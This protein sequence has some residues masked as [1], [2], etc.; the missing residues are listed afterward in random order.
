MKLA[1]SIEGIKSFV[2]Y[3]TIECKR[4]G[5]QYNAVA[6]SLYS[7]LNLPFVICLREFRRHFNTSG[8]LFK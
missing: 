3:L 5:K 8:F 2:K 1:D 4:Q 7:I 6:L